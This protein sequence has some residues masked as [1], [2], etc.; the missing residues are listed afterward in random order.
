MKNRKYLLIL[1]VLVISNFIAQIPYYLHQYRAPP[2]ILGSLLL[3]IVLGWFLLSFVW[4]WQGKTK[5]FIFIIGFLITEF[6]FYLSTQI[7]QA[8][9]GKG[10]LLHVINPNDTILFIVFGI[11]YLNL[12]V[13][14]FF[15]IF[16]TVNR[17]KSSKL[18]H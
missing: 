1:L 9:S 3:L 2:S 6:L 4:L 11:G 16:L 13:S 7:T 15:I 18:V 5:G 12:L 14:G 10:I 17:K 8:I